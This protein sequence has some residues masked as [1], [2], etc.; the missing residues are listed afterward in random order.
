MKRVGIL[1]G[2]MGEGYDSS[3]WEGGKIISYLQENLADKYKPVDILVDK[4]GLWHIAGV[5]AT[6]DLLMHKVDLVWNLSEPSTINVLQSF[7]IPFVNSSPQNIS[8]QM[9]REHLKN[10]GLKTPRSIVLPL[11]QFDFDGSK[12]IYIKKK[13]MEVFEKFSSPWVVKSFAPNSHMGVHVAKTFTELEESIRDGVSHDQSILVE[14]LIFGKAGSVHSLS[15]FRAGDIYTFPLPKNFTQN[16]KEKLISL[17]E[18]LHK[19]LAVKHYL[20]SDFVLHSN[21]GL[22]LLGVD[23]LPDLRNGS[24][25]HDACEQ[26]GADMR[27]VVEHMLQSALR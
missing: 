13:A 22:Y 26:V 3:I 23:F 6:P 7:S 12:D 10:I 9:F 17:A 2:G 18:D 27:Q 11:Y 21:R 4:N 24:H 19:H 20:K 16:E 15:G 14:E 25:F 5:P 1:R 8:G